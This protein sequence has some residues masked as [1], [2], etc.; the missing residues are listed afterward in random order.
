MMQLHRNGKGKRKKKIGL[1][2]Y[3]ASNLEIDGKKEITAEC[4][5]EKATHVEGEWG[6][7]G[8]CFAGFTRSE[9]L[10]LPQN[11]LGR[12]YVFL[13]FFLTGVM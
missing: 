4:R 7:S 3:V 10:H 2:F 13:F 11:G 6:E 1:G 5:E 12:L 9:C 8:V